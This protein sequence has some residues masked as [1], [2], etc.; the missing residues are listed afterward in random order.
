VKF[1]VLLLILY[2]LPILTQSVYTVPWRHRIQGFSVPNH[3][4]FW[5]MPSSS[6]IICTLSSKPPIFFISC[7]F[8]N[9]LHGYGWTTWKSTIPLISTPKPIEIMFKDFKL[10]TKECPRIFETFQHA[11]CSITSPS[12][13]DI[14]IPAHWKTWFACRATSP[15]PGSCTGC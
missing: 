12:T 13:L 2:V 9:K 1:Y 10:P 14:I 4:L 5:D 8:L 7:L 6:L 15:W 3:K 11:K